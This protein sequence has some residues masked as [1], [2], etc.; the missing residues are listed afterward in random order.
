MTVLSYIVSTAMQ[1]KDRDL[2]DLWNIPST[3]NDNCPLLV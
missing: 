1:A 3:A 2:K